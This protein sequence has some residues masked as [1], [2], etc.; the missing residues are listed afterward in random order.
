MTNTTPPR[1]TPRP[2]RT[3]R[4][5][6]RDFAQWGLDQA[7]YIRPATGD[8]AKPTMTGEVPHVVHAADGRTL[9]LMG[10]RDHAIAAIVQQGMQP[11]SVH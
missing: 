10:S 6:G 5:S 9:G 1:G 7:A 8:D 2:S 11:L 4:L 3:L